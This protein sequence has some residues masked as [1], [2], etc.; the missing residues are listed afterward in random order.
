MAPYL[1][2][3]L[4]DP[5][6]AVR[7][8]AERSLRTLPGQDVLEYDFL[9]SPADQAAAHTRAREIWSST[10]AQ[11]NSALLIDAQGN[12]MQADLQRLLDQRDNRPL[13]LVE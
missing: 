10:R 3:L 2:Q 5:Y 4:E 9:S 12:L 8:I 1:A 7:F 11:P 6:A 13:T